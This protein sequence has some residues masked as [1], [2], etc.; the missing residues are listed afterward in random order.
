MDKLEDDSEKKWNALSKQDQLDYFCAVVRRIFKG[1]IED[2]RSYRGVLYSV[3]EFGPEAY[4]PAQNAGYLAIHNAIYDAEHE[5][6]LLAAFAKTLG[7]TDQGAKES[8]EN[9]YKDKFL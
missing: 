4:A 2:K 8:V 3:F 6:D 7:L 1:E 5:R 9:F